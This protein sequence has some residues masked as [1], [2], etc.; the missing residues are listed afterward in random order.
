MMQM[1]SYWGWTQWLVGKAAGFFFFTMRV[2]GAEAVVA[3]ASPFVGAGESSVL[4]RP[5]L[6]HLTRAEIHQVMTSGFSTIAGSVLFAYISMGIS[7][8]VVVSS[9][10]MS[11]PASLVISK[12][13]YPETEGTLTGDKVD[14]PVRDETDS[15]QPRNSLQA[16]ADGTWLGLKVA[17][18]ICAAVLVLISLV[19]MVD[20]ILGWMGSY[21]NAP[22]LNLAQI[23]GYPLY[24]VAW[25]CGVS[26][27]GQNIFK[28][29]ELLGVKIVANEV[30]A[31]SGRVVRRRRVWTL[32]VPL[33][34]VPRP[35]QRGVHVC[36]V[37]AIEAD[38]HV[39]VVRLRKYRFGGNPDR[40][41]DAACA[42]LSQPCS[43][44]G[45]VSSD[46]GYRRNADQRLYGGHV[47]HRRFGFLSL[48]VGIKGK[49]ARWLRQLFTPELPESPD[50]GSGLRGTATNNPRGRTFGK[51]NFV[52]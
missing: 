35:G 25:L 8:K 9:C 16:L 44:P 37:A 34:V 28:V 31:V 39:C 46:L 5:Y 27:E 42:S 7:G 36:P 1:L 32:T 41:P 51:V 19:A 26:R 24:P 49:Q 12:L 21:L 22:G 23:L 2:S 33:P 29:A 3:A 6:A 50:R 10:V 14:I 40:C 30:K 11:I 20:A 13:R 43:C 38:R 4:I 17:G 45:D 47:D 15:Q 52:V 18:M 48:V